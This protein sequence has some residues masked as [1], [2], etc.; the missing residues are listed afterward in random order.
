[1][2]ADERPSGEKKIQTE[3]FLDENYELIIRK[4][5]FTP[6]KRAHVK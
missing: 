5:Y 3:N 1:M 2:F 4:K 6:L